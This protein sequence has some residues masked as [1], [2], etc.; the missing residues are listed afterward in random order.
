MPE[1]QARRWAGVRAVLDD[2]RCAHGFTSCCL[3]VSNH[4][5]FIERNVPREARGC[6]SQLNMAMEVC[7]RQDKQGS[8]LERARDPLSVPLWALRSKLA[9]PLAPGHAVSIC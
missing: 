6:E 1:S 9:L 5:L 2:R 4:L 7:R 8:A 3:L